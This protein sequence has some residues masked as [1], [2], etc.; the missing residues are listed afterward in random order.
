MKAK[1]KP[2]RTSHALR[3]PSFVEQVASH[4]PKASWP[5]VMQEVSRDPMCLISW[6]RASI[7]QFQGAPLLFRQI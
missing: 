5:L 7:P 1:P 4:R 3:S 2:S 6:S